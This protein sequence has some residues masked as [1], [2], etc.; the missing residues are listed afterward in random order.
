M[1]KVVV[2]A[3]M[4]KER[5]DDHPDIP[6]ASRLGPLPVDIVEGSLIW[7]G[8][9][10]KADKCSPFARWHMHPSLLDGLQDEEGSI[11]I[12]RQDD[13]GSAGH[14]GKTHAEVSRSTEGGPADYG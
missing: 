7:G 4:A 8:I 12:G 1:L 3:I 5:I 11:L 14:R 6:R 13:P 9:P 2:I 10:E